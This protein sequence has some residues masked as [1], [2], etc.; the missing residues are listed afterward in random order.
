LLPL[1]PSAACCCCW[2]CCCL[3]YSRRRLRCAHKI[4]ISSGQLAKMA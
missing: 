4:R 3:L 1:F 2:C